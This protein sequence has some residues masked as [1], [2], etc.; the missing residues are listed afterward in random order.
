M[1]KSLKTTIFIAT[2]ALGSA[3]FSTSTKAQT[4]TT[5]TAVDVNF[6]KVIYLRTF[7]T[8]PIKIDPNQVT[9]HTV[10]GT[11]AANGATLASSGGGLAGSDQDTNLND[12]LN[13]AS[14]FNPFGTSTITWTTPGPAYAVWGIG[15]TGTVTVSARIPGVV[16]A[17]INADS[18]SVVTMM[19]PQVSNPNFPAPGL[20]NP[21]TGT[22][23]VRLNLAGVIAAGVHS[24][25]ET[26]V[27]ITASL[28]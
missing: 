25:P 4:V 1:K 15:N 9:T 16:G 26:G 20:A 24:N 28:P 8:I 17:L 22:L 7:R 19:S 21:A 11:T 3:L 13:T 2:A 6:P 5:Q 27:N 10:A 12:G 14:P 23:S 18:G